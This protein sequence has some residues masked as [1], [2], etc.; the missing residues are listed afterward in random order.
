MLH[1]FFSTRPRISI[2]LPSSKRISFSGG[3]YVTDKQD[4]IDF[5][6]GEVAAGNQMIY[7]KSDQLTITKEQL[8]PLAAIKQRAREEAIAELAAKG[9]TGMIS[10]TGT[11]TAAH[12]NTKK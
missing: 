8:D 2:V 7:V 1:Q 10:S 3:I 9:S 6:N 11:T 4:E 12:S 5:L